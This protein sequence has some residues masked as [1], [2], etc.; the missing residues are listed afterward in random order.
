LKD[1]NASFKMKI[2]KEGVEV[3]SLVHKTSRVEGHSRALGWGLE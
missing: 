3:H 2:M 1:S